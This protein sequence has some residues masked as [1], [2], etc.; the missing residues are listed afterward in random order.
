MEAQALLVIFLLVTVAAVAA[1]L[2][3]TVVQRGVQMDYM[4]DVAEAEEA[5]FK[6]ELVEVHFKVIAVEVETLDLEAFTQQAV[7]A[8]W[9][10]VEETEEAVFLETV[11][12][13]LQ[14]QLLG[15]Q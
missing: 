13:V 3:Q 4:V 11:E 6:Q 9:A 7:V 2:D 15:H 10:L 5:G 12:M 8:E 14:I 1:V